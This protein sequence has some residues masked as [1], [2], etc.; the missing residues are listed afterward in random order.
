[1]AYTKLSWILYKLEVNTFLGSPRFS[2]ASGDLG[3]AI[4]DLA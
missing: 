3:Y 4:S 1:M 2:P